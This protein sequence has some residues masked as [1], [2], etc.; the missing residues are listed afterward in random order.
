M[1]V[2][3]KINIEDKNQGASNKSGVRSDFLYG[4]LLEQKRYIHTL[5]AVKDLEVLDCA[6]GIGWGSYLLAKAGAKKVVGVELS[7]N[8]VS[9]ARQYYSASNLEYINSSLENASLA[10]GSFDVIVSFETLEHVSEPVKFLKNLRALAKDDA[11]MFLS[12]P[13]GI[14]FKEHG[15]APCNP[16]HLDEYTRQELQEMFFEA[17]WEIAE[18]RGQYLMQS[19]SEALGS[20]RKFIKRFW[21]RQDLIRR[22]GMLYKLASFFD[23]KNTSNY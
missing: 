1:R 2:Q 14:A 23:G 15:D 11:A 3:D 9:S 8:A 10:N 4:S 6:S 19:E 20:Y 17:G 7:A 18:Y 21:R 12:T 13:N 5:Y 16:Y 22:F